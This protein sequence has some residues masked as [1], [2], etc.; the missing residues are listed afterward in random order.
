MLRP[1]SPTLGKDIRESRMRLGISQID[2]A[3]RAGISGGY[4]SAIE[5]GATRPTTAKIT[6]LIGLLQKLTTDKLVKD[7]A[8]G[9]RSGESLEML[10]AKI[11][12][13][14]YDVTVSRRG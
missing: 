6:D 9:S 13:K 5:T 7:S 4:L 1:E 3:Q 2:L 10:I 11:V 12:D 8:N 14:G